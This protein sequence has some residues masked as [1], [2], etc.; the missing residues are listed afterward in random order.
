[1]I[2][3]E[4]EETD[5]KTF[6]HSSFFHYK[7]RKLQEVSM[8]LIYAKAFPKVTLVFAQKE[9]AST[10]GNSVKTKQNQIKKR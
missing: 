9:L 4:G 10:F 3:S 5:C 8:S 6:L 7:V 2:L 1:M